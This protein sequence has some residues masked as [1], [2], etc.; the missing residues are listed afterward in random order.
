M[1]PVRRKEFPEKLKEV[2]KESEFPCLDV[3]ICTAD[4]SKEP[5]IGVVNT[6]LSV[7]AYDYPTEKISVYVSD[8]GGSK[9]TLFAFMEAAKFAKWWV[10]FCKKKKIVERSPHLFFQSNQYSSMD[11]TEIREIKRMYEEMKLKVEQAIETEKISCLDEEREIFKR[12][13]DDF[14]RQDHPTIIEVLLDST[15]YMNMPNLVYVS[16]EKCSAVPHHFKAGAL[17]VLLRVS[18]AMTNAPMILTLD[19]DMCSSNPQ[20]PLHALCYFS[21]PAFQSN[22][23]FVQFP[24][25]FRGITK[26]DIYACDFRPIFEINPQGFDGLSGTDYFGTGCFFR[27]RA[28]FGPPKSLIKPEILELGPDYVVEKPIQLDRILALTQHAAGCDYEKNTQWGYKIGLRYGSLV[29]DFFTGYSLHC[30]GWKSVFCKPEKAAF[31][32]DAPINLIDVLSQQ[33]RWAYGVLEVAFTKRSPIIYGTQHMGLL[34]GLAYAN[35]AFWPISSIPITIYAF[36]PQ[37]ALL[38]GFTIFPRVSDPIFLVYAFVVLGSYFQDFIDFLLSGGSCGK[39]WND[40]RFW[41]IRGLTC[42]SFGLI[43]FLFKS[44]GISTFAFN[45]TSKVVDDEQ[46]ER[47]DKGVFEFGVHSA[48]MLVLLVVASI[49]NLAAFVCGL[50]RVFTGKN[51]AE[52]VFAHIFLSGYAVINSWP[53][54]EAMVLRRDRGKFP[55][56]TS[57]IAT[58]LAL[59]LYTLAF[60]F[61]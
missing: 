6:A 43:E 37:L 35:Y 5:P 1:C 17:N 51:S 24:Q 23:A 12:W 9:F 44:L 45:I 8:D 55:S 27:R 33:T 41:M 53:V 42:H 30:E 40:Q 18:A 61:S 39:W 13:S 50:V 28:F 20:A 48:P 10:P 58:I 16:R 19:C 36:L 52:S 2:V 11:S 57:V 49:I 7:M 21:D 38:N 14:T 47:Y 29:E 22:L 59:S 60:L 4:A 32:G 26:H 15:K 56:K 25:R 54:Y 46:S 3:F 31:F 34:M